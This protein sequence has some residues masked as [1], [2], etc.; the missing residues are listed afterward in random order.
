VVSASLKL[1]VNPMMIMES[2]YRSWAQ[3]DAVVLISMP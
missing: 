3:S 1:T 2:I